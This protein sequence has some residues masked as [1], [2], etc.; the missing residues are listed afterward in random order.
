MFRES[1]TAGQPEPVEQNNEKPSSGIY[2]VKDKADQIADC[3]VTHPEPRKMWEF[4]VETR[5]TF[6]EA[7]HDIQTVIADSGDSGN[8]DSVTFEQYKGMIAN[9][10]AIKKYIISSIGKRK[11]KVPS[12]KAA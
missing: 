5:E 4:I 6:D 1:S 2:L 11:N 12:P 10:D 7:L 8:K 3:F 9:R